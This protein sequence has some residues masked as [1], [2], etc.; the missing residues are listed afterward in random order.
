MNKEANE[1]WRG[2]VGRLSESETA[3]FLAGAEFCRLGVPGQRRLALCGSLL[4]RV[5]G[6]WILHHP[7]SAFRLGPAHTAGRAC[8]S[9]HRRHHHLQSARSGQG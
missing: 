1:N 6:R 8:V 4:V 2:K 3:E 5:P 9:V 7:Q